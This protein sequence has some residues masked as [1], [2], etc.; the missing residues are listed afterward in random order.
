MDLDDI[1]WISSWNTVLLS[2]FL[3]PFQSL[4][5]RIDT[6]GNFMF[7]AFLVF[8]SLYFGLLMFHKYSVAMLVSVFLFYPFSF[9]MSIKKSISLWRYFSVHILYACERKPLSTPIATCGTMW[10][11]CFT[12]VITSVFDSYIK[13]IDLLVFVFE[14]NCVLY[15]WILT[16]Q[17][18]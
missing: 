7:L 16:V 10:Y 8:W 11:L 2:F 5:T 4:G 18:V 6:H 1:R 12:R 15:Q 9:K 14:F 3:N 17:D 13:E